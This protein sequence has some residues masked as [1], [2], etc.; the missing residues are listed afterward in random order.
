MS[1]NQPPLQFEANDN[2]F[3]IKFLDPPISSDVNG[4]RFMRDM[5]RM[6]W[7]AKG[8]GFEQT[9]EYWRGL[10]D[11]EEYTCVIRYLERVGWQRV[12]QQQAQ[13]TLKSVAFLPVDAE[14]DKA[15]EAHFSKN[16]TETEKVFLNPN[17]PKN[18]AEISEKLQPLNDLLI[19]WRKTAEHADEEHAGI[20]DLCANELQAVLEYVNGPVA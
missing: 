15:I 18:Q 4:D 11:V 16:A 9:K 2:D 1:K 3:S 13:V 5:G 8:N 6:Q 7:L 12:N 20:F 19:D 17:T 14:V 10:F